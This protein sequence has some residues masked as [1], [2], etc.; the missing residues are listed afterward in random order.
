MAVKPINHPLEKRQTWP[1]FYP[2][3]DL[4]PVFIRYPDGA[5]I[6]GRGV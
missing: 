2:P 4:L 5:R 1:G 3:G 6:V